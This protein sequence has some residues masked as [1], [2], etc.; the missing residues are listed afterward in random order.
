MFK[1]I[2]II[3]DSESY[4]FL[5]VDIIYDE[6]KVIVKHFK[7][8]QLANNY[9]IDHLKEE[10]EVLHDHIMRYVRK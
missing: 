6:V 9:S 7:S 2:C 1:V 10:L 4:S 8:L 3:L 5:S